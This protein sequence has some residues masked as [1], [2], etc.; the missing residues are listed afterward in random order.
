MTHHSLTL[1][2]HCNRC[3]EVHGGVERATSMVRANVWR[4]DIHRIR[5]QLLSASVVLLYFSPQPLGV[6]RHHKHVSILWKQHTGGVEVVVQ[7][8]SSE[9]DLLIATIVA[10]LYYGFIFSSRIKR[11]EGRPYP[12]SIHCPLDRRDPSVH[13][14]EGL[15]SPF[16]F[17]VV[18]FLHHSNISSPGKA[19]SSLRTCTATH[20]MF[21]R[22]TGEQEERKSSIT[23]KFHRRR[24]SIKTFF[25]GY[26]TTNVD[27]NRPVA[28]WPGSGH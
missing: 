10:C 24:Y 26:R 13:S 21:G 1:P 5:S 18:C 6:V 23:C 4:K 9:G 27:G 7:R 12:M 25:P 8:H 28:Q 20:V 22:N 14:P 17:M 2:R 3:P 11:E 15:L 19:L 16:E